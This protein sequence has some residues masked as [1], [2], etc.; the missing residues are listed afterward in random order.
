MDTSAPEP[1]PLSPPQL[2]ASVEFRTGFWRRAGAFLIDSVI[3]GIVGS[4]LGL[5]FTD[6]FIR[7]GGW[8]RVI[9]FGVAALYFVPLNGP[10]GRGQTVGKKALGIRVVSKSGLPLGTARSLLRSVTLMLPYF[11]NGAPIPLSLLTGTV[12]IF[13][14]VAVFGLGFS[15][16]YL[17]AFNARTRQSL[18]DLVVGSYVV[19][20]G[21][22]TAEKPK[23]W[24]A[25]LMVVAMILVAAAVLPPLLGKLVE[26]WLPKEIMAAYEAI[27]REPEVTSTAV[28]AGQT[29]FWDPAKG[30]RFGTGVTVNVRLN[31]RFENHDA[32][33]DK[34]VRILLEKYPD[35]N[36][37]DSIAVTLSE[38]YDLGIASWF[39]HQGFNYSPEQWRQRLEAARRAP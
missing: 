32:E 34:I 9:G 21:S 20:V 15:I 33:A 36:T 19:R 30:Q 25:H 18:H 31:R 23:I 13:F 5:F 11:L 10:L 24:S 1:P 29:F 26:N 16:L 8:G 37:K 28:M 6:L 4:I 7:A 27:Q 22:E 17:I 14:S 39:W 3:L 12:G 2:P 35:A 38:G